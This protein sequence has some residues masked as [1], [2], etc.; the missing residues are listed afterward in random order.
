MTEGVLA[1]FRGLIESV[2]RLREGQELDIMMKSMPQRVEVDSEWYLL[3]QVWL[4]QWKAWCYIDIINAKPADSVDDFRQVERKR[5]PQIRFSDLF[6]KRLDN[7]LVDQ[8]LKN[9]WQ[10]YQLRPDLQESVDYTLVTKDVMQHF[11]ECYNSEEPDPIYC[12][13]RIGVRQNDGEVVCEMQHRK[14][15]FIAVPNRTKY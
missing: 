1:P 3:P 15:S 8:Q 11:I 13:K 9:K 10:N 5:P 12:F 4:K 14:F 7:Q 6:V 2:D